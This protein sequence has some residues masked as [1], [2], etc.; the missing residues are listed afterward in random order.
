[1]RRFIINPI[2]AIL[3]ILFFCSLATSCK[4]DS[5]HGA[6]GSE[7]E[8]PE[9]PVEEEYEIVLTPEISNQLVMVSGASYRFTASLSPESVAPKA[10]SWSSNDPNVAVVDNSG[11]VTA[12]GLGVATIAASTDKKNASVEVK[13]NSAPTVS[14]VD[15]CTSVVWAKCNLGASSAEGQGN[16][17]SWGE[18]EA[19]LNFSDEIYKWF[20][21]HSISNITILKYNH[22][23]AYGPTDNQRVLLPEDD[24]ARWNLG[25]EW[26]IPTVDEW[27]ELFDDEDK[28]TYTWKVDGSVKYGVTIKSRINGNSI[29]L[30]TS[31]MSRG[32]GQDHYLDDYGCYWT[33]NLDNEQPVY[34]QSVFVDSRQESCYVGGEVEQ[35]FCRR[36]YG[37]TIRPVKDK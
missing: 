7:P 5:T 33:A 34:A 29:F 28:F 4:K 14:Y 6:S 26:R 13:V 17:Y 37:M 35:R 11:L 22:I 9:Q 30:P 15:M 10:I 19:G 18:T 16:Y 20:I 8:S 27:E 32:A 36:S 24:A 3:A 21:S 2:S 25:G 23:S 1:M 12:K 31:S